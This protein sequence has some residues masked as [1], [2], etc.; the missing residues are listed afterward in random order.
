MDSSLNASKEHSNLLLKGADLET[1]DWLAFQART[2]DVQD[3]TTTME[4]I[5]MYPGEEPVM[6]HPLVQIT[7]WD[8]QI[9]ASQDVNS[10]K[11]SRYR[12]GGSADN[13]LSLT[14]CKSV[15]P[16]EWK[17]LRSSRSQDT[18]AHFS[19]ITQESIDGGRELTSYNKQDIVEDIIGDE[20]AFKIRPHVLKN[21]QG[22]PYTADFRTAFPMQHIGSPTPQNATQCLNGSEC[23][24]LRHSRGEKLL[25]VGM[26]VN[27][28][29]NS[30]V[31][32]DSSLIGQ[33]WTPAAS[34]KNLYNNTSS[35]TSLDC[36]ACYHETRE[37]LVQS[38]FLQKLPTKNRRERKDM[39][40]V[41]TK[42]QLLFKGQSLHFADNGK[43]NSK[44]ENVL[45]K[46]ESTNNLLNSECSSPVILQQLI[47]NL[48]N[49]ISDLQEANKTAALELA[50]ADEEISQLKDEM[51]LLKSEYL[52]Q[53]ADYTEENLIL[54]K[55]INRIHNR[56]GPV[57]TYEQALHEEICELRSESRRLR[58]ITHH[59]N[60]ENHRLK[61]EL[62]DIKRQYEWLIHTTTGKQDDSISEES[63]KINGN[64]N[65]KQNISSS[66]SNSFSHVDAYSKYSTNRVHMDRSTLSRRPFAP[67][68]IADLKVGN[69]VKFSQPAGKISKGTVKYL[70]P[71]FGREE[72]YLGI[73]LEGDQV[74]RHDGVFRGTRYFLCE[75]NKGVFVKFNKVIIAW[76]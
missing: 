34:P 12:L 4:S 69:L 58:E 68:S 21:N 39:K 1:N 9:L 52:Q 72:D 61:E 10:L 13:I 35:S 33:V 53:L 31:D 11:H 38:E 54:K 15:Q 44:A 67:R 63:I 56:H 66:T 26:Q 32:Q 76:E 60:E 43:H 64:K 41:L 47:V 74:G 27:Q 55:K 14:S 59:L 30:A 24:P 17:V 19:G 57:D 70:G 20:V 36:H 7:D 62:W 3:G 65:S 73:E 29:Q 18:L 71:L 8:S 49:Q 46:E 28:A 23:I 2:K 40:K 75:P 37:S 25:E 22:V 5:H 16:L 50:N 45:N 51:V 48:K 42:D 6:R